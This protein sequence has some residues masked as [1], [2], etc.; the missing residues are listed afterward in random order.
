[1]RYSGLM[2]KIAVIFGIIFSMGAGQALAYLDPGT[3][4]YFFQILIAAI[5]GAGFALKMYWKKVK[6]FMSNLFSKKKNGQP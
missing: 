1:M 4:S 6:L 5:L 2:T 3:G